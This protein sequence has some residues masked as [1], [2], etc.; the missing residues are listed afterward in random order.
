VT[1]DQDADSFVRQVTWSRI[2]TSLQLINER[3]GTAV[4][5]VTLAQQ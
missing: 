2:G 1:F 5:D 4:Y 3:I